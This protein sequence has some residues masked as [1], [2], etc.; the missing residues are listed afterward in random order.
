MAAGD[1]ELR[2]CIVGDGV[3]DLDI[4]VPDPAIDDLDGR[5][6]ESSRTDDVGNRGALLG[7]VPL[8][9]DRDL[10][11]H[12]RLDDARGGDL[13]VLAE[14][15]VREQNA[16]IAFGDAELLLYGLRCQPDLAS[17]DRLSRLQ[18]P[19]DVGRLHGVGG[20]EIARRQEAADR[21]AG[22]PGFSRLAK[23]IGSL[24]D[25]LG[26]LRGLRLHGMSLSG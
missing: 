4:P 17:G 26:D 7:D 5:Q 21:S 2:G 10:A 6:A 25:F 8:Q 18:P 16:G 14:D 20:L 22:D 1:D 23:N 12:H 11:L 19:L 3:H 9:D 13:L 15:I 24:C